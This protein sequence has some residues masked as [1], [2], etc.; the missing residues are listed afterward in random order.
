MRAQSCQFHMQKYI[1][2]KILYFHI[3]INILEFIMPFHIG[4]LLYKHCKLSLL[5]SFPLGVFFP[6]FPLVYIL[7]IL[8]LVCLLK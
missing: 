5:G 8:V 6:P 7:C 4:Q 1:D 3:L 2:V